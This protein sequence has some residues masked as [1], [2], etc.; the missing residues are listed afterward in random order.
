MSKAPDNLSQSAPQATQKPARPAFVLMPS[1][2]KPKLHPDP[3][4]HLGILSDNPK[5]A[6]DPLGNIDHLTRLDE[7]SKVATAMSCSIT[8]VVD[9]LTE[10]RENQSSLKTNFEPAQEGR[11]R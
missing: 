4:S 6:I 3:Q 1:S 7:E 10:L 5:T 2:Q 11:A 9:C 8:A